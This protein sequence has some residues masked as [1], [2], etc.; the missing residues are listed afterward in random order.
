MRLRA[1]QFFA[2]AE[3]GSRVLLICTTC[4]VC[5]RTEA[6]SWQTTTSRA[7]LGMPGVDMFPAQGLA[8]FVEGGVGFVEQQHRRFGQAHAGEQGALQFAAGQG[9]QR[10]LFQAAE[11]PVFQHGVQAFAALLRG[12][13]GAPETGGDQLLQADGELAIEVLLLG[14]ER[15]AA[16]AWNIHAHFARQRLLQAGDDF[17]AGCFCRSRWGRSRR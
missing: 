2:V 15:H 1:D 6:K 8:V 5:W 3:H 10:A 11:A 16:A 17:R 4:W 12:E 7:A 14:Q 13:S 9:H